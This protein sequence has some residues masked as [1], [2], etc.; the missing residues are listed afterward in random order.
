MRPTLYYHPLA[1]FC[2]KALIPLYENGIAFDGVI[3]DLF[4][5]KQAA[6]FK[7]VWP[8]GKFPVLVHGGDVVAEASAIVTW[9]DGNLP[10][11]TRFIPDGAGWQV[12]MWDSVLDSYVHEQMQKI[13]IDRL[14]PEASRDAMGVE[15][16]RAQ[17]RQSYD[18]LEAQL[19]GREWLAADAYTLADVSASPALF[20]ANTVEPFS[21]THEKLTAYV[22]RLMRRPSFARVLKE[23]EPWF[24]NFPLDPKPSVAPPV[25]ARKA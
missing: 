4:D 20:Y 16:A 22:G 18:L 1:S 2:W 25:F 12:R 19:D 17:L 23:A 9:L 11:K 3:V 5:P 7:A 8:M 24:P 14:R 13:V 21:A 10:G 6:D 15:Q